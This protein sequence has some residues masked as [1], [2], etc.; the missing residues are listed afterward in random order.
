MSSGLTTWW[1]DYSK[2]INVRQT[3]YNPY[4]R[5]AIKLPLEM[6]QPPP[7]PPPKKIHVKVVH[8]NVNKKK[9]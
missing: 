6:F 2:S 5:Y 3:V 4:K 9:Y 1:P 7:P 8:S